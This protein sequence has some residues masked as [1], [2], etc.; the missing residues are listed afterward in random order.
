MAS[1]NPLGG[2]LGN[3]GSDSEEDDPQPAENQLQQN[4]AKRYT[5]QQ[6]GTHQGQRHLT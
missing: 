4:G 6:V 1:T 2:L 3:Y 5:S